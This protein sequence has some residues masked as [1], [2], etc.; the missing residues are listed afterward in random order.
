MQNCTITNEN[1]QIV[2]RIDPA[3]RLGPS[4]SGKTI[5]VATTGGNIDAPGYPGLKIGLN[6]Y[7]TK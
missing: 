3:E 5:V 4:K 2:I 1:G 7:S 6:A